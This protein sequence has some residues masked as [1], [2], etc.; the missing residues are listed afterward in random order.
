[1]WPPGLQKP[2][3]VLSVGRPQ[4]PPLTSQIKLGQYPAEPNL[5]SRRASRNNVGVASALE[6]NPEQRAAVEH[7]AGPLLIIAGPG[8]GKTRVITQRIVHLLGGHERSAAQFG[9]ET[10]TGPENILALTFTDKA[11]WEMRCRVHDALPDLETPPLIATFHSFCNQVLTERNFDQKL[12]DK[13]D[14]WIFLR[15]RMRS[16]GLEH[17]R[18][19]A[20]PGAFLHDLNEFFSRCQ[21]ELLEPNEFAAYVARLRT[22]FERA[23]GDSLDLAELEKKEELTRVF[24]RSRELLERAG[25]TSFGS[26]ISETLRLWDREPELLAACRERFRYVLVDEFQDSNFAQMEILKRLVTL[27]CNITAVGDDDQAIYRFRGA[28]SGAFR[29]F[30]EAFP[31]HGTVYLNRNYRS[32]RRILRASEVVIAKNEGRYQAKPP[33]RTENPEGPRVYLVESPG[34]RSE[35]LWVA[36]EVERLAAR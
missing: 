8:T 36:D 1:L 13:V 6:L 9:A 26:L 24:R 10:R 4:G 25:C 19:L 29:M 30:D 17:Y 35:A 21:D 22:E 18:K 34:D 7:G 31:G 15:R 27:G 12:L 2:L 11:A 28:S 33:L 20:E 5:A 32:T 3:W 16:L 23:P 14:L